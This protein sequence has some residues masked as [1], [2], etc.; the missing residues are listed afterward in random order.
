M[1][2]ALANLR[3]P[4]GERAAIAV[5]NAF[6]RLDR[7]SS[8]RFACDLRSVLNDWDDAKAE[9][10]DL[11]QALASEGKDS[12]AYVSAEDAQLTTPIKYPNKLIC[13]GGVYRDHLREF[14]LPARRWPKMPMFLRPP[15]TS[16]VGPGCAI[17]IPPSTEQFDWEIELAVVV[18]KRLTDGD[19]P[20]ARA[21]I[22]GYSVGID[23]TCRDLLDRSS[24]LGVDL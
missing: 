3:T 19:L 18:G 5:A 12:S 2:F 21:A 6:F 17:A 7:S 8:K 4:D 10:N 1:K 20:S 15:T 14:N 13:V 23:L 9:L 22:A 11:A 24:T 16:I